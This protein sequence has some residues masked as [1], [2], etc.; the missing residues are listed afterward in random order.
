MERE[1]LV[2]KEREHPRSSS[3]L[4]GTRESS[5]PRYATLFD[6]LYYHT[7]LTIS[8]SRRPR[9]QGK[10]HLLVTRNLVPGDSVY[11]EKRISI[12]QPSSNPDSP[13][14]KVEY[15]VWNP[16]RSKLA[17]GILGGLDNIHIGPGKKV[18]YLGAA[19][20]TSVSHVADV[21]GPV[22]LFLELLA[23]L[24][25]RFADFRLLLFAGGNCLRC[26]ILPPIR[27]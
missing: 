24:S 3:S 2:P 8:C 12:E 11:G 13:A 18:L 4:T 21:V 26:R 27:S 7:T 10:E 14:E 23:L 1:E 22:S 5:L 17:A 16:F 19:S 25:G 20:G 9:K 6:A 15:R